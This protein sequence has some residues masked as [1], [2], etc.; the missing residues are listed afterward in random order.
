MVAGQA[1][2]APIVAIETGKGRETIAITTPKISPRKVFTL[3]KPNRL[4]IDVPAIKG[5]PD[6]SIPASYDG[7]LVSSVRFGQFNAETSRFVFEMTKPVYVSEISGTKDKP[8]RLQVKFSGTP[9]VARPRS[10]PVIV[11]D[12][13]HGGIDP[14]TI[15]KNKTVE[16][17]L[18]LEYAKA[19]KAKLQKT[20]R[21]KVV[22]TREDDRFIILRNRVAIARKAKADLFISVHADSAPEHFARGL[23]VYTL[24]EKA[25]DQE[26]AALAARENTADVLA[27]MDLSNEREDVA[28]ILISLAQRETN[29][30]S[31]T[32]ADL[33]V[34]SMEDRVPLLPNPHRFAGFAVLKAPDIPSVLVETGFLSNVS[35]EKQLKSKA[36]QDK[37]ASGVVAGVDAYFAQ[38]EETESE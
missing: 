21:Y 23:S 7:D 24:S 33:L 17:R 38:K 5:K 13:G 3:E 16:K 26:A 31:A 22:L 12:P 19:I 2:A 36:Y 29:N 9:K 14:G 25:S 11:I 4:V 6:V 18:V 28:D 8:T 37:V 27:G 32:L 30:Y 34:I 35:E 1:Q 15:G 20:N 10:K